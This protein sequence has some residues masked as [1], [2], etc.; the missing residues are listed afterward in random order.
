MTYD[1]GKSA[2]A[3]FKS[4]VEHSVVTPT[5][6]NTQCFQK[7][8]LNNSIILIINLASSYISTFIQKIAEHR[9]ELGV[10]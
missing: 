8:C 2:F 1:V 6:S 10:Q 5:E 9:F 3:M 4:A 7:Y